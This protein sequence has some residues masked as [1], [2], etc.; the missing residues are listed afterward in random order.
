MRQASAQKLYN[1][2]SAIDAK[3]KTL[4]AERDAIESKLIEAAQAKG[5]R[6]P[7]PGDRCIML[8]D[9]FVDPKTGAARNVAFKTAAIPHYKL[10]VA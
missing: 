8:V 7:L 2:L 10:T 3:C 1:R 4:Y 6:L 9:N 5:G